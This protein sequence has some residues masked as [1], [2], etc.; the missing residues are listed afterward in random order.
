MINLSPD[1]WIVVDLGPV[2][3]NAT[4][5]FT[6]AVMAI[7]VLGAFLITRNLSVGPQLSQWQNL[8]EVLV[9]GVRD[10]IAGIGADRPQRFL[11]LI[12][13][14]FLFVAASNLLAIVPGYVPPTG[15]L[16]TTSALSIVVL[17]A[18]PAYGISERGLTGYLKGYAEP[19]ILMLPFNVIGEISRTIALAV[20]L[21][22]NV[23]SG[24]V[25]VGILISIAPFFFPI[26]MR[27]FG[28]LTGFIQAYI[29]A[30]LAMVYIASATHDRPRQRSAEHADTQSSIDSGG[31]HG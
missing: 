28:M 27:L 6:W 14:L 13:T 30:V 3:L 31:S 5:V 16:S 15:S 9:T 22:G 20:R 12:G 19:T 11:P 8:L 17:I 4:I 25:I 7:L 10:Q 18:A 21:Y 23:M 1:Q 2:P 29:F 24:T 26:A